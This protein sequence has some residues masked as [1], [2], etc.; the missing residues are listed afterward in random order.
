M[1]KKKLGYVELFWTCPNC[2]TINPGEEK[3]CQNCGAPQPEDVQFEQKSGQELIKD[4]KIAKKVK[5]GADIHC[6]YCGARNPADAKT[7]A[8]CGGDLT[9]GTKRTSGRIVGAFKSDQAS[10]IICPNCGAENPGTAD[11]CQ[12]CGATLQME[13]TAESPSDETLPQE[14]PIKKKGIPLALIIGVVLICIT[15]GVLIFLSN[16]TTALTGEVSGV[17]WERSVAIEALAPVEHQDWLDQIPESASIGECTEEERYIST[18]PTINSTEVCGTPYTVDTGTGLGEVVQDCEYHVFDDYCTYTI[19]EWQS[20][21]T[22]SVSGEDFNA[23]WPETTLT[24]NQRLGERE[25]SYSIFFK[26]PKDNYTYMTHDF[27]LFKEC[28]IGSKWNLNINTFGSLVSI[29]K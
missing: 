22:V 17:R 9:S 23:Y 13:H 20:V 25:E 21:D 2:G 14:K 6:P 8:Q 11:V 27:D 10:T 5:A 15:A 7:C 4:E 19:Q 16:K 12:Q 26:T 29:E 28:K 24:E 1:A 3:V 18:E